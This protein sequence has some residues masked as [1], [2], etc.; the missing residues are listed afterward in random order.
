MI[1]RT[2]IA[3][4]V[5]IASTCASAQECLTSAREVWK[6]HP[7]SWATW[8][9][10]VAGHEGSK[11]WYEGKRREVT[12]AKKIKLPSLPKLEVPRERPNSVP[13][14]SVNSS[15]ATESALS[16]VATL[17]PSDAIVTLLAEMGWIDYLVKHQRLVDDGER[18]AERLRQEI[19]EGR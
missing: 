13:T 2:A 5:A 7:G 6:E 16:A 4:M 3:L 10:R 15:V 9:V 14:N 8:S 18:I 11:C 17:D 1:L 19:R 12:L